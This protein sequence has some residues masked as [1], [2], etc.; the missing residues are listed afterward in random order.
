MQHAIFGEGTVVAVE[1]SGERRLSFG[2]VEYSI[3]RSALRWEVE[4]GEGGEELVRKG[5]KKALQ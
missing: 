2:G 4:E 3:K 5:I 1:E